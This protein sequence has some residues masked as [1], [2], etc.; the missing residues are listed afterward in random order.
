MNTEKGILVVLSG[1]SGAGKGTIV[2]KLMEKYGSEYSL[3][4]SA[5]TRSPRKGEE[6]GVHYFFKKKEQFEEMIAKDELIEHACY[7]GNYYGTPKAYVEECIAAGKSV[8]LEIEMQGALQ[9]RRKFPDTRL[10]FV[11][12]PSAAV[13]KER[14]TGRGT[15]SAEVVAERLS[16]AYEESKFI[17]QYDYLIVNDDLM[18]AVNQVHEVILAERG[19]NAPQVEK[20]LVS[21]NM[22]F[23]RKIQEEF[24]NFS[25]S[26]A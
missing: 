21:A 22:D 23:V 12:A 20:H 10:L 15:E 18:A 2:E 11:T 1:F 24:K 3:S 13:L 7:V 19:G 6:D 4:I 26:R 14:L 17:P 9:I 16:H 8:I 25:D 5:T